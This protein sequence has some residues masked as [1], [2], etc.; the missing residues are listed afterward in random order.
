VLCIYLDMYTSLHSVL[1]LTKQAAKDTCRKLH[2]HAVSSLSS[3]YK[4]K[5]QL[6]KMLHEHG[7]T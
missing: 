7:P 1:G 2:D 6:N 5:L 4:T 3:I